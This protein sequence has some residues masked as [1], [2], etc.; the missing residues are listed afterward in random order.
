MFFIGLLPCLK[1]TCLHRRGHSNK[2][3]HTDVKETCF[4]SCKHPSSPPTMFLGINFKGWGRPVWTCVQPTSSLLNIKACYLVKGKKGA[5]DNVFKYK[6]SVCSWHI[7]KNQWWEASL[8]FPLDPL[9]LIQLKKEKKKK[10][11]TKPLRVKI[12]VS[13]RT[14]HTVWIHMP[15][16]HV[17][18]TSALTKTS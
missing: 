11:S 3:K 9:L 1:S 2:L 15:R 17:S 5:Q 13:S 10:Q 12:H 18:Q 4:I 8:F 14:N 6:Y 7:S 16:I